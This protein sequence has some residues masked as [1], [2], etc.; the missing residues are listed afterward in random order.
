MIHH[1][2]SPFERIFHLQKNKLHD[3]K[4]GLHDNLKHQK[5]QTD[6]F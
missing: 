2:S 3:I 5:Q 1:K 4:N 6:Y